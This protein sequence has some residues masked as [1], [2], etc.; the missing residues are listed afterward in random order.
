MSQIQRFNEWS[1]QHPWSTAPVTAIILFCSTMAVGM[2]VLD[3]SARDA[4]P[5]SLTYSIG[6]PVLTAA[7][8]TW[9]NRRAD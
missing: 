9:R 3:Q 4:L 5:F 1:R 2:L 8:N 6:F 7:L